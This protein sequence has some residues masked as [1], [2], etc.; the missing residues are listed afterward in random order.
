MHYNCQGRLF[1]R[2]KNI[3]CCHFVIFWLLPIGAAHGTP[4][5]SRL[6][7]HIFT[8]QFL[9]LLFC[10]CEINVCYASVRMRKQ[11]IHIRYIMCACM[12]VCMCVD[13]YS[14]SRINELQVRVSI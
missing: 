6:R 5:Y 3:H 13:C 2:L 1:A 4:F 11:S 9:I 12:C 8:V 14:C 10:S 7:W